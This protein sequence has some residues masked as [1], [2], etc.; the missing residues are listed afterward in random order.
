[1]FAVFHGENNR[2]AIKDTYKL[3]LT[4][5][6]ALGGLVTLLLEL[7]PRS[8][9]DAFGVAD[10]AAVS[11]SITAIRIFSICIILMTFNVV[12]GYYYQ[13]TGRTKLAALIVVL[14]N[15]L[16]LLPGALVFGYMFGI[17]GIWGAYIFA[18]V[19]TFVLW[20]AY[21][22]REERIDDTCDGILLLP[23]QSDVYSRYLSADLHELHAV[24]K[25]IKAFFDFFDGRNIAEAKYARVILA[26]DELVA[27][28]IHHGGKGGLKHIEI[29]I[30]LKVLKDEILLVIRDDGALFDHS[31]FTDPAKPIREGGQGLS[32][33]RKTASA[34]E[35]MPTLGL[36]RTLVKY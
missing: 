33:I 18:E 8:L 20:F 25:E 5:T 14:R 15:L 3:S 22:K 32:L 27:N 6:I 36:N 12:M 30:V 21:V 10:A 9:V 28:V 34:F 11:A 29:R 26:V 31:A 17:N 7:F 16:V 23:R 4:A 13:S 24:L 19:A 2:G 35:Y 1:M